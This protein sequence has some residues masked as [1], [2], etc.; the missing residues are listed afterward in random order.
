M[1]RYLILLAATSILSL[2]AY[3]QKK[4]APPEAYYPAAGQWESRTPEQA[5]LDAGKLKVAIGLAIAA[6]SKNPRSMEENHYRTFGREPFGEA[7]GPMKDR[8]AQTGIIIRNGFAVASWGE[9]DRPDM[10]HSVTKSFL[11]VVTGLA[12]DKGL[13]R[14]VHDTVRNYVPPV[15]PYRHVPAGNKAEQFG[16]PGLLEPFSSPHNRTITWDHLLRQ[17]SDWEGNL[18]GKPEWAD[19]PSENPA[20]WLTRPRNKPGA[21]FEYNDVRVNALALAT[22]MVWRRPLPQVLKENLMDPIGASSTWRW[23][24]YENSWV[25]LDGMAVQSVSG[26]GHWGGGMIINGWDMARFG[27]LMLRNGKWKDRQLISPAWIGL[28]STPTPV[29]T[30]YGFMNWYLNTDKKFLPSAPASAVTHVGNGTNIIYV[31]R[32][33]DLVVVCRWVETKQLDAIIGGIIGSIRR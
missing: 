24:G 7:I 3:P 23:Y 25:V 27:Y 26:G 6:E 32:E 30:D 12:V 33:N 22:L 10:T 21:V 20:D 2:T 14:S 17:T 16:T 15:Q 4:N 5:G 28:S 13:I 9:P 8:G 31:D 29:K 18:W 11:S 1:L 19:R